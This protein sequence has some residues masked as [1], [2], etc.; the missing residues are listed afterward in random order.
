M[1]HRYSLDRFKK[2]QTAEPFSV[3]NGV[4]VQGPGAAMAS[5]THP[6]FTAAQGRTPAAITNQILPPA[7][8]KPLAAEPAA[9]S[10]T[11][12]GGGQSTWQPPDWAVEPR[13]GLHWLDV[14]KDGEVV[15]KIN[16]EKRRNIFGRQAIMCD[17]VLDHPSVSRQHAVVVQ[18][19]NGSVYV[20]D[21]GSVHGT[22]VANERLSKDSPVELEVGQSLKFAASTRSY[23]LRKGVAQ[24]PQ[25]SQP[26]LNFVLPPAPDPSDEEAVVVYNTLLNK[27]G[28]SKQSQG[29]LDSKKQSVS[30]INPTERPSKKMRKAHVTFRDQYDGVLVEVVGI[31]DG[32]DVSTEP[33]PLGVKEGSLVGRFDDLVEITV[34]PKGKESCTKTASQN[35]SAKGVTEKLQQFIEKVKSPGKGGLYDDSIAVTVGASWAKSG[36]SDGVS[37]GPGNSVREKSVD[38]IE[39]RSSDLESR[40]KSANIDDD[41]DD[42]FG[43]A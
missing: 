3:N 23:V 20:I 32:A 34:I 42:L 1:M 31:S 29:V 21:L 24:V 7:P 8:S 5:Q 15:D 28:M 9:A 10:S 41:L 30:H 13:P 37:L 4:V 22:F 40:P 36:D 43:D 18:H 16:L 38:T 14:V 35:I 12:P 33:G 2:A 27:L 19:K 26:P 6:S 39:S 11:S 17:F 25:L